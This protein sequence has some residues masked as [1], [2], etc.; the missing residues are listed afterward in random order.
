MAK[1]GPSPSPSPAVSGSTVSL[2]S[3]SGIV[4]DVVDDAKTAA[5]DLD[6]AK[7]FLSTVRELY[8][9]D[10]VDAFNDLELV[11]YLLVQ[12][13]H[14]GK[15][16]SALAETLTWRKTFGTDTTLLD[17][18]DFSDLEATGKAQF[19]GKAR[20][21]T[22]ILVI[23]LSRHL[24]PKDAAAKEREIRDGIL[25]DKMTVIVD[26][27]NGNSGQADSSLIKAVVPLFQKHFPER[28]ARMIIFPTNTWFWMFWK[29]AKVFIDPATVLKIDIKDGA[30]SL[31]A[32]IDSDQLF[33]RYG[34][35]K[36]D[37]FEVAK[38]GVIAS[39]KAVISN[40]M[41]LSPPASP[42]KTEAA[43]VENGDER[44]TTSDA[45]ATDS[46]DS[47]QPLKPLAAPLRNNS[48]P[49]SSGA[50]TT[51]SR[52][53]S[54]RMTFWGSTA[55]PAKE[56]PAPSAAPSASASPTSSTTT[57]GPPLFN[58]G[59]SHSPATGPSATA[60]IPV[61]VT[62][63]IPTTSHVPLSFQNLR[64]AASASS[65]STAAGS[66]SRCLT[67]SPRSTL[68]IRLG[69]SEF[70]GL[71]REAPPT[72]SSLLASKS[73]KHFYGIGVRKPASV[74]SGG[75]IPGTSSKQSSASTNVETAKRTNSA[76]VS[77]IQTTEPE[78][79][80]LQ[81]RDSLA[82]SPSP[83]SFTSSSS[84][85]DLH[86]DGLIGGDEKDVDEAKLEE[87]KES[88]TQ[89]EIVPV[90]VVSEIPFRRTHMKEETT[91]SEILE[92]LEKELV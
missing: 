39:A 11:K 61:T 79:P 35:T 2:M 51:R 46:L 68:P 25:V 34:G 87:P 58:A 17:S 71:K 64:H 18:E 81:P 74:P 55:T 59:I 54:F 24:T 31:A 86:Q 89:K 37:P 29:V 70:C 78:L 91:D 1:V 12:K 40:A 27:S 47:K 38:A 13:G 44:S 8:R 92:I 65:S 69:L 77:A 85:S 5:A 52:A 56:T 45:A 72:D 26:R 42:D 80:P 20:D 9:E 19:F 50:T 57:P 66:N 67:P 41:T 82:A 84:F 43:A 6:T 76:P 60:A 75:S 4:F 33:D 14:I 21:G 62:I 32:V 16:M 10:N 28:L 83:V 90:S 23:N 63:H 48:A 3:V 53:P 15:A 22:P 88:A 49:S 36:T 30:T 73:S 7:A